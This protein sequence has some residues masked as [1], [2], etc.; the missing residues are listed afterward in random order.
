MP[1]RHLRDKPSEEGRCHSTSA[2]R[3]FVCSRLAISLSP[4]HTTRLSISHE[5]TL[6]YCVSQYDLPTSHVA[7][8][9]R[10]SAP[11]QQATITH[12]AILITLRHATAVPV[13]I[14]YASAGVASLHDLP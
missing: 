1:S 10:A 4:S 9:I 13:A 14:F 8:P 3:V 11:V 2:S 12:P 5:S 7:L 6:A